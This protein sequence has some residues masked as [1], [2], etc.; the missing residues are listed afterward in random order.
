MDFVGGPELQ[1]DI[2]QDGGGRHFVFF[3]R[4]CN[5]SA[6]N[7]ATLTEFCRNVASKHRKWAAWPKLTTEV[8]SRCRRPPL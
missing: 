1:S 2:I 8:N 4:K 7:W 6:A 3:T 5:N